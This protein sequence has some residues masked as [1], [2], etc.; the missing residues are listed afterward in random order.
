MFIQVKYPVMV[1]KFFELFAY[2]FDFEFMPDVL[3]D[4]FMMRSPRGFWKEQVD[5]LFIRN[6]QQYVLI[7]L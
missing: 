4:K 2:V 3:G 1:K 7:F 6:T 5:A